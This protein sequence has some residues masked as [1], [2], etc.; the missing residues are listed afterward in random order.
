MEY[1]IIYSDC[2]CSSKE[3]VLDNSKPEY[4]NNEKL[5]ITRFKLIKHDVFR[6]LHSMYYGIHLNNKHIINIIEE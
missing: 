5:A 4:L 2:N 6:D 3:Y 1:K